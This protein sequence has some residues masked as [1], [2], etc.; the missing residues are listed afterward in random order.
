LG[1]GWQTSKIQAS[2]R[3]PRRYSGP[4]EPRLRA[5]PP[6]ADGAASPCTQIRTH[7]WRP[8]P[9]GATFCDEL[10]HGSS[11]PPGADRN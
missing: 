1:I 11:P 9:R 4:H 7:R 3:L 8:N 2:I 6:L 10:A 5:W